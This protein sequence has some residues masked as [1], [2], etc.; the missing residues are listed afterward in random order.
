[1]TLSPERLYQLL[2]VAHRMR[3][4]EIGSP[5]GALLGIISEQVNAVE[6]DIARLYDNWFIET[7]EDWVV[8]YIGDLIGFEP[9]QAAGL[10]PT[11]VTT[12]EG[13]LLDDVLAPR[14]AVANTLGYRRRKGTLALL[15]ELA[16]S[17]TGWPADAVEFYKRLRWT[18]HLDHQRPLRARS[19]DLRDGSA[20]SRLASPF[21]TMAR[22]VDIRRPDSNRRTG[23]YNIPSVGVFLWRLKSY[24][25]TRAPAYCQESDG[26]HCYSFSIIGNDAPLF[27]DPR[28]NKQPPLVTGETNVP[29][30]IALDALRELTSLEPATAIASAKY[31]GQDAS[32]AVYAPDWPTKGATQPVPREMIVPSDLSDWHYRAQRNQIGLDPARG[33]M[34][35]PVGQ[36]PKKGVWVDYRYGFSADMGGGEY[37]RS[38]SQPEIYTLYNVTKDL[39][40][41]GSFATINAALDQWRADQKALGPE[42]GDET[43]EPA[44]RAASEKLRAAVVEIHDSAAYSE[45]LIVALEA[46]EYL[47]LRA[48]VGARP[49]LRMLDYTGERPDALTIGGRK[50]SRFKLDGI[51][52]LGRN[53]QVNGPD[54]SDATRTADDDLCDVVIRHC[55]LVPGWGLDCGC[56]PKRPNEPSLEILNCRARFSIEH[57]ILGPIFVADSETGGDPVDISVC[58]SIVDATSPDRVA[59]GAFD[60]PLA[61]ARMRFLRSTVI[62]EVQCHAIALAHDAIFTSMVRVGRRQIGCMRFCYVPQGSR[63]PK[64][65]ECQPDTALSALDEKCGCATNEEKARCRDGEL[66]RVKPLFNSLRYGH[67]DYCQLARDCA[68]EISAG[69]SDESEMG[70]FHDLF[71]PQRLANLRAALD[72]YTPAGNEAGIFLAT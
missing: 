5:L 56:E 68:T 11:A 41:T 39:S 14:Q 72:Q 46:G 50:S 62:G 45:P 25:V 22:S 66:L 6:E 27:N 32:V 9:A 67:P 70:A 24:S 54:P 37:M 38:V 48:A 59:V 60:L 63:T 57:S 29:G 42:P 20:L 1:M 31:Y 12:R 23:F 40:Q 18:Q 43:L 15:E 61:F 7:C 44:W 17:L 26:P 64:R 47:Q 49:V 3:D 35:F 55:T 10:P 28:P 13:R 19:A 52:V 21:D 34:V 4:A 65:F 8:P 71:Q 53:I 51:V 2:P 16:L 33:R 36:L 58:D 69:A 30:R